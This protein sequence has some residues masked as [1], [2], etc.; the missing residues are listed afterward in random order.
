MFK[1]WW[2]YEGVEEVGVWGG[3]R[4]EGGFDEEDGFGWEDECWE[5]SG[6]IGGKLA[7]LSKGF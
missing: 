4:R 6:D 5:M 3:E 1:S 2:W 7:G